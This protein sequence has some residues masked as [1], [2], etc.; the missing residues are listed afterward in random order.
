MSVTRSSLAVT[1]SLAVSSGEGYLDSTDG[2]FDHEVVVEADSS[3]FETE[4]LR[5]ITYTDPSAG[6]LLRTETLRSGPTLLTEEWT[7]RSPANGTDL[8]A[9]I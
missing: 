4:G 8:T 1:S 3:R 7:C 9:R 6:A 5:T 2:A